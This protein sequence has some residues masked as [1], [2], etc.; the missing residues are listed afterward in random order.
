MPETTSCEGQKRHSPTNMPSMKPSQVGSYVTSVDTSSTE[1]GAIK[2]LLCTCKK[3]GS[4]SV[5]QCMVVVRPNR[6]CCN[7]LRSGHFQG[8]LHLTTNDKNAG[9]HISPCYTCSLITTLWLRLVT[10]LVE[11]R[12]KHCWLEWMTAPHH[13]CHFCLLILVVGVACF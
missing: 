8:K 13:S 2:P 1:W 7:C 4:L 9:G 11:A 10:E 5:E 6:L 12:C 3:L